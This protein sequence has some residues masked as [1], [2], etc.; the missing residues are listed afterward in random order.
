M[1]NK[2]KYGILL[3]S[4]LAALL[5]CVPAYAAPGQNI[6][7]SAHSQT[8]GID[9]TSYTMDVVPHLEKG[10]VFVP[11]RFLGHALGLE[12]TD[13]IWDANSNSAVFNF[14]GVEIK[15][16][17]GEKYIYVNGEEK[18]IDVVPVLVNGRLFLP[19]SFIAGALGYVSFWDDNTKSICINPSTDWKTKLPPAR[20]TPPLTEAELAEARKLATSTIIFPAVRDNNV[21]NAGIAA[22]YAD[23]TVLEPGAEFSFNRVVGIRSTTRGFIKGQN[24]S[25]QLENGGG[26]CRTSTVIYQA[27]KKAGLKITERHPHQPPVWYTPPG[28]DATVVWGAK[29][30]RFINNLDHLITILCGLEKR[31]DGRFALYAIITKNEP[32]PEQTQ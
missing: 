12:D 3:L 32:T 23:G 24:I 25:G 26:V 29:D 11:L 14:P 8:Y 17:P 2:N 30:M 4:V 5:I 15:L 31:T 28:T 6:I 19:A 1:N 7:F 9:G 22:Q 16:V 27:A 18:P 13:I 21:Y 10:R 20:T